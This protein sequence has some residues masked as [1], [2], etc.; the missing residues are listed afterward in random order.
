MTNS[1]YMNAIGGFGQLSLLCGRWLMGGM[2]AQGLCELAFIFP[3]LVSLAGA[4]EFTDTLMA[5]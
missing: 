3:P 5:W 1:S 4:K 2:A